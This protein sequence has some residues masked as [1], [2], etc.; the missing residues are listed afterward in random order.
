MIDPKEMREDVSLQYGALSRREA[1]ALRAVW[2]GCA[3]ESQQ[4]LAMK[5]ILNKFC[6]VDNT[7]FV[8]GSPDRGA[9]MAGRAYPGQLVRLWLHKDLSK[10]PEEPT[11]DGQ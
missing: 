2:D 9:F 3:D 6:I 10:L 4:R 8:P 11:G 5:V 7:T 1:H